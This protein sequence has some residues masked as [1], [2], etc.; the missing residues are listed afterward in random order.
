MRLPQRELQVCAMGLTLQG[1]V[2]DTPGAS[3]GANTQEYADQLYHPAPGNGVKTAAH[4]C[5]TDNR[6]EDNELSDTHR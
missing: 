2:R 4:R 6:E 1:R 5:V 3:F